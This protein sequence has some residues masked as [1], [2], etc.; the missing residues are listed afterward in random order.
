M[1]KKNIFAIVLCFFCI[2]QMVAQERETINN[3]EK[4]KQFGL[5][6]GLM[7]YHHSEISKGKYDWD[8]VFIENVD[9]LEG[10][11]T[12]KSLDEFLL[13]FILSIKVSK[14]KIANDRDDL[15]KRN[16]DYD[17]IEK[18]SGNDK[19]YT[20]LKQL[21]DNT[22]ISDYYVSNQSLSKIPTFE[23]EK[24][25]KSFDY[26]IKVHRLLELFS[27]WNAIQYHYV[28]KYLM[29]KNWFSQLEYFV[30]D[31]SNSATQLEYELA[32]TKLIV[33][34]NDSHS[35]YFAKPIADSLLKFRPPFDVKVINDTLVITGILNKLGKK[36]DLK[37]GD[38]IVEVND[39]DIKSISKQKIGSVFSSSND[40]FL[41]K[42]SNRWLMWNTEDSIKVKIKRSNSI[43]TKY[44]H[45]Y[46][47]F[48]DKD[49]SSL[50]FFHI[51][52]EWKLI[53]NNIGYINLKTISKDEIQ[54]AFEE[55]SNTNG[56]IIDLRNY[57]KNISE[58]D[59]TKYT[60]PQKRKFI[61]VL[62]PMVNRPSLANFDE[63]LIS[64]IIDPFKSGSKN[65]Q[66][67]NRKIILLVDGSTQS[68]AEFIGM[69]IQ[70][71]PNCITVGENTAGSVL[72]I[73]VFT[74]SD[75]TKTNFTSVGAF[76]PDGTGVQRKG[77]KIDY[78]VNE[79][80]SNFTK[81][82]YILKGIELIKAVKENVN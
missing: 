36:D 41:K 15:F 72:N 37:L 44:I 60:Y 47:T 25:F 62:F 3:T 46:K 76:Y 45:L 82:Q 65:S 50:P 40:S 33:S 68:K 14:I 55:F 74:M 21:K 61:K 22:I 43:T 19:L 64:S 38:L 77:L 30:D 2:L 4:Y 53:D 73:A 67:Y 28:N 5:V 75:G 66:Y 69:A 42:W 34:L 1:G 81:D 51:D 32:K 8:A 35:Y 56:I 71:S 52:K 48:G 12:Q 27:F 11:D 57:P 78:F 7:K 31:F 23:N 9:K 24:G 17:W 20:Y 13:N 54:K 63:P 16:L 80:T 6:W 39:I 18:Y 59:I 26:K 70:A 10:V 58:S 29:D 49:Y 79:N